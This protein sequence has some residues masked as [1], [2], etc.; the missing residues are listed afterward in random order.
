MKECSFK[1]DD[2]KNSYRFNNIIDVISN[3]NI[4]DN[5]KI[6]DAI[7]KQFDE[8][9]KFPIGNPTEGIPHDSDT[10]KK[11]IN[12]VR[13]NGYNESMFSFDKSLYSDSKYKDIFTSEYA[14]QFVQGGQYDELMKNMK[15]FIGTTFRKIYGKNNVD[16]NIKELIDK[17]TVND[18]FNYNEFRKNFDIKVSSKSDI[19]QICNDN[20]EKIFTFDYF[21]TK[22]KAKLA[23]ELLKECCDL[24][25][26]EITELDAMSDKKLLSSNLYMYR[27]ANLYSIKNKDKFESELTKRNLATLFSFDGIL[28]SCDITF[29]SY[30]K[31][32]K[33]HNKNVKSGLDREYYFGFTNNLKRK[34]FEKDDTGD[35][36]M[37]QVND[38]VGFFITNFMKAK[39]NVYDY[40]TSI[41][42]PE[43]ISMWTTIKQNMNQNPNSKF[44]YK[45]E[46][47]IENEITKGELSAKMLS[48]PTLWIKRILFTDNTSKVGINQEK[49]K[50]IFRAFRENCEVL[51]N[52]KIKKSKN[53]S[54]TAFDDICSTISN[55][56]HMGYISADI[57]STNDGAFL[58]HI[59]N[60]FSYRDSIQS[61]L[62]QWFNKD[63]K[64]LINIFK[65]KNLYFDSIQPQNG[66]RILYPVE[67][68]LCTLTVE[69]RENK[70]VS[71]KVTKRNYDENVTKD[72]F[73]KSLTVDIP[74]DIKPI[75]EPVTDFIK[76]AFGVT[77]E[78]NIDNFI[79]G[80]KSAI[81]QGNYKDKEVLSLIDDNVIEDYKNGKKEASNE[82]TNHIRQRIEVQRRS[83]TMFH[84]IAESVAKVL[85][86]NEIN[87]NLIDNLSKEMRLSS[88]WVKEKNST[89]ESCKISF[90]NDSEEEG[91]IKKT[92][93]DVLSDFV[94][95]G[96]VERNGDVYKLKENYFIIP[97]LFINSMASEKNGTNETRYDLNGVID[98]AVVK[99]D[100]NEIKSVVLYDY[101]C[102]NKK[103]YEAYKDDT[104][105]KSGAT[106]KQLSLYKRML[107]NYIKEL[108]HVFNENNITTKVIGYKYEFNKPVPRNDMMNWD[109]NGF[110]KLDSNRNSLELKPSD[111]L[112]NKIDS[113][114]Q[115]SDTNM[116]GMPYSVTISND[117]AEYAF[118]N[119]ME[120]EDGNFERKIETKKDSQPKEDYIILY[121]IASTIYGLPNNGTSD[122]NMIGLIGMLME[123]NK[124]TF[125]NFANP[126]LQGLLIY[127]KT[128]NLPN[129]KA[130]YK[131]RKLCGSG[132]EKNLDPKSM[133]KTSALPVRENNMAYY[134]D[135][136]AIKNVLDALNGHTKTYIKSHSGKNIF[137][138]KTSSWI[139]SAK[140]HYFSE[141]EDGKETVLKRIGI[142]RNDIYREYARYFEVNGR[143][144]V[145]SVSDMSRN[146]LFNLTY[147]RSL[148]SS[149]SN[150]FECFVPN[151]QADKVEIP[152]VVINGFNAYASAKKANKLIDYFNR[153]G[154]NIKSKDDISFE[155]L[156][157]LDK[158]S[159]KELNK[160]IDEGLRNDVRFETVQFGETA[161]DFKGEKIFKQ[162]ES[163][164][165]RYHNYS[166]NTA[167]I[168][169]DAERV[170]TIAYYSYQLKNV[171]SDYNDLNAYHGYNVMEDYLN[172]RKKDSKDSKEAE[173][174]LLLHVKQYNE[175]LHL[176][177]RI[178]QLEEEINYLDSINDEIN[179][180][181]MRGTL[182]SLKEYFNISD[183]E[184]RS[185]KINRRLNFIMDVHYG[186]GFD[187]AREYFS[188]MIN[189]NRYDQF[190]KEQMIIS[191]NNLLH[192]NVRINSRSLGYIVRDTEKKSDKQV[193][194]KRFYD[195]FNLS[196]GLGRDWSKGSDTNTEFVLFKMNI[197]SGANELTIP[198]Y[199]KDDLTYDAPVSN[200]ER[201]P[202]DENV[203]F[204]RINDRIFF[205]GYERNE[206][207][208]YGT[209]WDLREFVI[210]K[211]KLMDK[212]F[213]AR[214]G[215]SVE[216]ELHPALK[217]LMEKQAY[218]ENGF[219]LAVNGGITQFGK[220]I[221]QAPVRLSK[222]KL[223][224]FHFVL[225]GCIGTES[226]RNTKNSA[227]SFVFRKVGTSG[228]PTLNDKV[229]ANMAVIP[230]SE[231]KMFLPFG[232]E[233][234]IKTTDGVMFLDPVYFESLK[235][236][237]MS[238]ATDN[239]VI[240][241]Y[242][243]FRD[244]HTG[245]TG[246]VKCSGQNISYE[247]IVDSE[248]FMRLYK[249]MNSTI[250][251]KD[252]IE[253][254]MMN[255]G[256]EYSDFDYEEFNK[257][258]ASSIS[259]NWEMMRYFP[260]SD[261]RALSL[262][263]N[264]YLVLMSCKYNGD[265]AFDF[266]WG[267]KADKNGNH[268]LSNNVD[269]ITE[270]C[271]INNPYDLFVALGGT[272][273]FDTEQKRSNKVFSNMNV[274]L[275]DVEYAKLAI[276][277]MANVVSS[278]KFGVS[279]LNSRKTLEY[280]VNFNNG[281]SL[282]DV[283]N[284]FI[285]EMGKLGIK[286][287]YELSTENFVMKKKGIID[288]INRYE[289]PGDK[290]GLVNLTE[291]IANMCDD[292]NDNFKLNYSQCETEQ[293]GIQGDFSDYTQAGESRSSL[294]TQPT[295]LSGGTG[296]IAKLSKEL[297]ESIS[298]MIGTYIDKL[299]DKYPGIIGTS[300]DGRS[301]DDFK[302]AVLNDVADFVWNG[303]SKG[304]QETEFESILK[305]KFVTGVLSNST[306]DTKETVKSIMAETTSE[307]WAM[308]RD[309]ASMIEKNGIKL[310]MPGDMD[311]LNVSH[312][313][314]K[315][316]GWKRKSKWG[317]EYDNAI[318][319]A[320][321]TLLDKVRTGEQLSYD[322]SKCVHY[323]PCE[324]YIGETYYV[325]GTDE[326]GEMIETSVT[327]NNIDDYHRFVRDIESNQYG[328]DVKIVDNIV[329]GRNLRY[330]NYI[331]SDSEGKR[332][333]IW[334]F[335][336]SYM[337][338]EYLRE[339][340]Q[341]TDD[342]LAVMREYLYKR[343]DIIIDRDANID[344]VRKRM[345]D[346]VQNDISSIMTEGSEV[347]IME[348]NEETKE[349]S[350]KTVILSGNYDYKPCEC[351]M[352]EYYSKEFEKLLSANDIKSLKMLN[353]NADEGEIVCMTSDGQTFI[354]SVNDESKYETYDNDMLEVVGEMSTKHFKR[355]IDYLNGI[356]GKNEDTERK[357]EV[358]VICIGKDDKDGFIK[359]LSDTGIVKVNM[360]ES[361]NEGAFGL[362][363]EE[364]GKE[365]DSSID[366]N[367]NKLS[368]KIN[369]SK[370][371]LRYIFC[372]RT[373]AQSKQ[374]GMQMYVADYMNNSY[375][376]V[377]VSA[378]QLLLHGSDFDIDKI[379]MY[380]FELNKKTG[381]VMLW[382]D[383]SNY[384]SVENVRESMKL[385]LPE[386]I[387]LS[388]EEFKKN[389]IVGKQSNVGKWKESYSRI[390]N[391][392]GNQNIP[393]GEES[394]MEKWKTMFD[395]KDKLKALSDFIYDVRE[396][397]EV[398]RC[399]MKDDLKLAD[400]AASLYYSFNLNHDIKKEAYQSFFVHR[401]Q[402]IY[403]HPQTY[404][405]VHTPVDIYG[406]VKKLNDENKVNRNNA[407]SGPG[408]MGVTIENI[409]RAQEGAGTIG[410]AATASKVLHA[411]MNVLNDFS[412]G[413]ATPEEIKKFFINTN[414]NIRI[415]GKDYRN[416][417]GAVKIALSPDMIDK[418][419]EKYRKYVDDIF[420]HLKKNQK[421]NAD[422]LFA[423]MKVASQL[424]ENELN[425][426]KNEIK[427]A[428]GEYIE[429]RYK[430]EASSA[431]LESI[432]TNEHW[433][434]YEGLNIISELITAAV[435]NAKDQVL[436]NI[437]G[438]KN[439][440]SLYV[441]GV[442]L[443][444]DFNE[445]SNI[446]MSDVAKNM[447]QMMN[448]N[449][450]E[451]I[452][453]MSFEQIISNADKN[454][455]DVANKIEDG[456]KNILIEI[457]E[458]ENY[459]TEADKIKKEYSNADDKFVIEKI[460]FD[461]THY[462]S[463]K[464]ND[465]LNEI[466]KRSSNDENNKLS[467]YDKI[468][469]AQLYDNIINIHKISNI[470]KSD[471]KS[472]DII[473]KL[474][475][476]SKEMVAF[477]S[478]ANLRSLKKTAQDILL[479]MNR[480]SN[481]YENR[482]RNDNFKKKLAKINEKM[483]NNHN[484]R[485]VKENTIDVEML[486][487]DEM[488]LNE[489]IDLQ[490]DQKT[491]I[492]PL[493]L[494][495]NNSD[496]WE[497]FRSQILAVIASKTLSNTFRISDVFASAAINSI[498][499]GKVKDVYR[500]AGKFIISNVMNDYLYSLGEFEID[501]SLI[502]MN[503]DDGN[504]L[505]FD[506]IQIPVSLG[507]N[508]GNL[509]FIQ[510]VERILYV[511]MTEGNL[512][513]VNERGEIFTDNSVQSLKSYLYMTTN[514]SLYMD[515]A[516]SCYR[517]S[518]S[519][520]DDKAI[521]TLNNMKIAFDQI[522][523]MNVPIKIGDKYMTFGQMMSL[524]NSV[525]Y[526]NDGE[527][528]FRPMLR[529]DPYYT[530]LNEDY[531]RFSDEFDYER[532]SKDQ[533][534]INLFVE[535]CIPIFRS[536]SKAVDFRG[537]LLLIQTPKMDTLEKYEKVKEKNEFYDY[538]DQYYDD[539]NAY[540]DDFDPNENIE[541]IPEDEYN[542]YV[543]DEGRFETN[544]LGKYDNLW[545][546]NYDTLD[547]HYNAYS[548]VPVASAPVLTKEGGFNIGN[549]KDIQ[550][551]KY[552]R[553]KDSGLE[554]SFGSD[555]NLR[556]IAVL[557]E[558]GKYDKID[559]DR[560]GSFVYNNKYYNFDEYLKAQKQKIQTRYSLSEGIV[561]DVDSMMAQLKDMLN[562]DKC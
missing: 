60:F 240:K 277:H 337:M 107:A 515:M 67:N 451:N 41:S 433:N 192:D 112:Q 255:E 326:T 221:V 45:D 501:G 238:N 561:P 422:V 373:P 8:N 395:T 245:T 363:S 504:P 147:I 488:Y 552:F 242:H 541:N 367:T 323:S 84:L 28:K 10:Y 14:Q 546:R 360:S 316:H 518:D 444:V 377:Y 59:N 292:Y 216:Y 339:G 106:I 89:E 484:G 148:I 46:Q 145:K 152:C 71:Y 246:A 489:L 304:I 211:L 523:N 187:Y 473:K 37:E 200:G 65:S 185:Q 467:T 88:R 235:V 447:S 387:S 407:G 22:E 536:V 481:I 494:L 347:E 180:N 486:V 72:K 131:I 555:G 162:G 262:T 500:K 528:S 405:E 471:S 374:S 319:S 328:K 560:D 123:E 298:Y 244:R 15:D 305:E 157:D 29:I 269:V 542:K 562:I 399:E 226:K 229:V 353:I 359:M 241:P 167:N 325:I 21:I 431:D 532:F 496:Y 452:E 282:G 539:P 47:G 237:S 161:T 197:K 203:G 55:I 283:I 101:K 524:Y 115:A 419:D 40:E 276:V 510:A 50:A 455:V 9:I 64:N 170:E 181:K 214:K 271:V 16:D 512:I 120:L 440:I 477:S 506:N 478:F 190:K 223:N 121:K 393:N 425:E 136:M 53:V 335:R 128:A 474:A 95:E 103:S 307:V 254:S 98:L 379:T 1:Y 24:T 270:T 86:T 529:D 462:S 354:V 109:L 99:K 390:V 43:F 156:K 457:I 33:R 391:L 222:D 173:E 343:P 397:K 520:Y 18:K 124:S 228:V 551:G 174:F 74:L 212:N 428:I 265:N 75:S 6:I 362:N 513:T 186:K 330:D 550:A 530:K 366:K 155:F 364:L 333:G 172:R 273:M 475:D 38:F 336:S 111:N 445:L 342:E 207:V 454:K 338:Y 383:F 42:M 492:N 160:N 58:N 202:L 27:L 482:V 476:M 480:W 52:I 291:E 346:A 278:T 4:I 196:A 369:I 69:A 3:S 218:L 225:E 531:S 503:P 268:I 314:V 96:F 470:K 329:V 295:Y 351:V 280:D 201:K 250:S 430:Y 159:E 179:A 224:D 505:N 165:D 104:D 548:S 423:I 80:I 402:T 388:Y 420:K 509:T 534:A 49:E 129:D 176:E 344:I 514:K 521:Q 493:Y 257:N 184:R 321:N 143:N 113:I 26:A 183:Y 421:G 309:V 144:G 114:I 382:S 127:I 76:H 525:M 348:Y 30:D 243:S 97:E 355:G 438:G 233:Y 434:S 178:S 392:I 361:F 13:E 141:V 151:A 410:F 68:G 23:R 219:R 453:E 320:Q 472:F 350:Q 386:K 32:G 77:Q 424:D 464:R 396:D 171:Y 332:Y 252:A 150:N 345:Q 522:K 483:S 296:E 61:S 188:I 39:Y 78:F 302:L 232:D 310:K 352:P 435:D 460:L 253:E 83:G 502:K 287:D 122:S 527:R 220:S 263:G 404:H 91:I 164:Y 449:F 266:T 545:K 194:L 146:D 432:M 154:I 427:R 205:N 400:T 182:N 517:L 73:I 443:G 448:G 538:D 511:Y 370:E 300:S 87:N 322:E 248:G 199:G 290:A 426:Y 261:I 126:A 540:Y 105:M 463:K 85:Q 381:E 490:G 19:R 267:Y 436:C 554:I 442:A 251:F 92:I 56:D 195:F 168:Y 149:I 66:I 279:N 526:L 34:G 547:L 358:P 497:S 281:Q 543:E 169:S 264:K 311:V 204:E 294:A 234:D 125:K 537:K 133:M 7:F 51:E 116:F 31:N 498:G 416:V 256:K 559:I 210:Y 247:K 90:N 213:D 368:D 82:I 365:I 35:K 389:R 231:F 297:R 533:K 450:Y 137:S 461:Y 458:K 556:R 130:V 418:I 62:A 491:F 376:N 20:Y 487:L 102:S 79:K 439:F 286:L 140:A 138:Q 466:N 415:Q 132:Y 349:M 139:S 375:N 340:H 519:C 315:I 118:A 230:D 57:T 135:C 193:L 236:S 465:I 508:F 403:S 189:K 341:T 411:F 429:E 177:R 108:G 2:V 284:D 208:I 93:K 406:S 275:S 312:N 54:F 17:Y 217:F 289:G 318:E 288:A 394:N 441:A 479:L 334:D 414:F 507:S 163:G 417:I 380:L 44:L 495:R 227:P 544:V 398:F 239:D 63:L 260:N 25:T 110:S 324:V 446:L 119:N 175:D 209:K 70:E 158:E 100:N 11:I 413:D 215:F 356:N 385:P 331:F 153:K 535:M 191:V 12:Y 549:G 459:N 303:I 437:N 301:F 198:V 384:N 48:D 293:F 285:L 308:V 117:D 409:Q 299:Y 327:I 408:C 142:F 372:S 94:S 313:Y 371:V 485:Q 456:V 553:D 249:K 5:D 378:L 134:S 166:I 412:T 274:V 259:N 306:E 401:I 499:K 81:T 516:Y 206:T 258:L 272:M 469:Y 557:N 558:E 36:I 317:I 357:V 468:A